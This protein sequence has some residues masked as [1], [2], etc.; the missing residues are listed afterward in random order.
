M[1]DMM[2]NHWDIFRSEMWA[3]QTNSTKQPEMNI[4]WHEGKNSNEIDTKNF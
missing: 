2:P 3:D 4:G 1:M